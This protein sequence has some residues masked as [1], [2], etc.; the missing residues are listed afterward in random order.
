MKDYDLS[1]E[2]VIP[3]LKISVGEIT[4]SYKSTIYQ[5]LHT[6]PVGN[7]S[8][9]LA[10]GTKG[11]KYHILPTRREFL[12]D[13]NIVVGVQTENVSI[14]ERIRDAL[15]GKSV[16]RYGLPFA[17]DNNYLIDTIEYH[18]NPKEVAIWYYPIKDDEI[19][20]SETCRLTTVI[21][22][23]QNQRTKAPV[24]AKTVDHSVASPEESWVLITHEG[25]RS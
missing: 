8:S 15:N 13:L 1:K 21:D 11:A 22:R 24:F 20:E 5:Q 9:L 16:S 6:Y 25:A 17:G 3:S 14:S 2:D 10:E 4:P 18:E 12:I 19:P 23:S 7:A